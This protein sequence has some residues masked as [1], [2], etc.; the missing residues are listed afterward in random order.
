MNDVRSNEV[1]NLYIKLKNDAES[2]RQPV[3]EIQVEKVK[4]NLVD[5]IDPQS[6][7]EGMRRRAE[8]GGGRIASIIGRYYAMDRDHR[9]DRIEGAYPEELTPL[10]QE[11]NG[12]LERNDFL[13]RRARAQ[14]GDLAH[15][16]K[17]PLT[18]L[19]QYF[20]SQATETTDQQQAK[21]QHRCPKHQHQRRY[22]RQ[23]HAENRRNDGQ[24]R[25]GKHGLYRGHAH[26]I[27]E[28][29]QHHHDA[30]HNL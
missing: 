27:R 28:R 6:L 29:Q 14:V 12:L 16:L 21:Q 9:W 8:I 23:R 4:P 24:Q 25:S 1:D 30:A 2:A 20:D 19:V 13:L 7:S 17:S 5:S 22:D 15:A 18:L 11:L 26:T 3:A 10:V